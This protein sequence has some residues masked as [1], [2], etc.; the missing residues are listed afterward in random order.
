MSLLVFS[1]DIPHLRVVEINLSLCE[2]PRQVAQF[3]DQITERNNRIGKDSLRK[4]CH[5]E[6]A[7]GK[8]HAIHI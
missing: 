1:A 7:F 5:P 6:I 3:S 8:Q 2:I 4:V